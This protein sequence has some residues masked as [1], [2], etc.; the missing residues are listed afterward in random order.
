MPRSGRELVEVCV[1]A[2]CVSDADTEL[3][4][5]LVYILCLLVIL[6]LC[7]LGMLGGDRASVLA[8]RIV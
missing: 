7:Q 5:R 2:F 1:P 3:L 8:C 4:F 6:S